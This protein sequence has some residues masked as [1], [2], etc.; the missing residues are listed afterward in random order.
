MA[1]KTRKEGR[2]AELLAQAMRAIRKERRMRTSEV[3]RL[4]D[5]PIRSYEHFE[6]GRGKI[7]FDRLERFAEVTECDAIALFLAMAIGK[8]EFA[9]HCADNKIMTIMMYAM[10]ELEDQLGPDIAYLES[11]TLVGGFTKLVKDLVEHV[12][13]RDTFAEA[14]LEERGARTHG[15]R[16][17]DVR[18]RRRANEEDER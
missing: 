18:R 17:V 5:M 14:W 10:S 12:R 1:G 8:P 13:K 15:A 4:L 6:S 3:A 16:R 9:L 11:G 7:S 2:D